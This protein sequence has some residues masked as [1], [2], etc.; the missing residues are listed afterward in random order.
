MYRN[1]TTAAI[2]VVLGSGLPLATA[3]AADLGAPA[4]A[5][6]YAKAPPPAAWSWTGFYI[7]ANAGYHWGEI[8]ETTTAD[9][10]GWSGGL[11]ASLD[12]STPGTLDRRGI[13]AGGQAG[14]NWQ[15]S[16]WVWGLEGDIDYMGGTASR[17]VTNIPLLNSLDVF[18]SSADTT[19][20][21]TFRGRAGWAFDRVLIY[22][23]GGI[24]VTD[25]QFTDSMSQFATIVS[26]VSQST[27][28]A[29]WTAGG[30]LE[31][32]L[33]R[34]WTIKG[35]YLFADFGTIDTFIPTPPTGTPNS[36]V[37]VHQKYTESV[38]RLGVNYKFW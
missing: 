33:D 5:P 20:L 10:I 15:I 23:T 38:A 6:I 17:S 35:E 1:F 26:S 30:G 14:Y 3:S 36:D 25:A 2:A 11:A 27:T 19:Y 22:G 28:R 8:Q 34:N 31:Y 37:T 18:S 24:A 9:P 7:G 12:A 13:A 21:A 32:A 29:G 4:P 16:N